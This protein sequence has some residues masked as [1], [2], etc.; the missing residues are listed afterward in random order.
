MAFF[1]KKKHSWKKQKSEN[2]QILCSFSLLTTLSIARINE[3]KSDLARVDEVA[4]GPQ[5]LCK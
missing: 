4:H 3:V 1:S 5:N 2:L